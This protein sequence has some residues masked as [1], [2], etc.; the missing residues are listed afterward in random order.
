[1]IEKIMAAARGVNFTDEIDDIDVLAYTDKDGNTHEDRF[2][3][4]DTTTIPMSVHFIGGTGHKDF[5]IPIA[6]LT[7]ESLEQL[8]D[9]IEQPAQLTDKQKASQALKY[10]EDELD[11]KTILQVLNP[12]LKDE[13]LAEVF[14]RLVDDGAIS[15]DGYC[16]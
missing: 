6:R 9:C 1:M 2:D 14:D 8:Y 12:Y 3:H 11:A 16:C 4:I 7:D 13:Q 10:M 15:P 5:N